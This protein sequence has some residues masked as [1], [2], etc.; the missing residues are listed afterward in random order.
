[1]WA[2]SRSQQVLE[3]NRNQI[4]SKGIQL[5][6][7][8]EQLQ[9]VFQELDGRD[10]AIQSLQRKVAEME[11]HIAT[12]LKGL[13]LENSSNGPVSPSTPSSL[14]SKVTLSPE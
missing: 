14:S 2:L 13:L 11:Q 5:A 1:M 7:N 9:T 12:S 4:E 8:K 3:S 6:A 10:E